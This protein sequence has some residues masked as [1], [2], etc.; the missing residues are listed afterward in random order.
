MAWSSNDKEDYN[1][2]PYLIGQERPREVIH[3]K[4]K[5]T[6]KFV[7]QSFVA[8]DS[9]GINGLRFTWTLHGHPRERN[10]WHPTILTVKSINILQLDLAP[11]FQRK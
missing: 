6:L 3:D 10:R 8:Q 1:Y 7:A 5:D 9:T 2:H 11:K 4:G